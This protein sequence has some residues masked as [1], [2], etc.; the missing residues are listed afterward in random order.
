MGYEVW[1]ATKPPTGVVNAYSDKVAWVLEY[2]PELSERIVITHN[3]G[4]LGDTGDFLCDDR[5]HKADC[6]S[7]SGTFLRFVDG[8][9]WPQALECLQHHQK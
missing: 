3:K 1:I 7:F 2:L 8:F 5:P 9:H 4:F 6:E